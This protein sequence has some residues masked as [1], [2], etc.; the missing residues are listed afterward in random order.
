MGAFNESEIR[1][2]LILKRIS[3]TIKWYLFVLFPYL[4]CADRFGGPL[5]YFPFPPGF[6]RSTD[7]GLS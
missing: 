3:P 1:A 4:S 2:S 6:R 5:F 7:T